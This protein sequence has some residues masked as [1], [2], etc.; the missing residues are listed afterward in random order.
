MEIMELKEGRY[1]RA[2]QHSAQGWLHRL[3]Q[4]VDAYRP[5]TFWSWNAKLEEPVLRRQITEMK[6]AGM[7]GFFMHARSGLKTPY[8]GDEWFR[9]VEVAMDE[10]QKQNMQAWCYDESGWP[11]GFAGM[12]LL[13]KKENLAHY[14]TFRENDFFDS[15]ALAVYSLASGKLKRLTG[16]TEGVSVYY[17]VYDHTNSSVVDIMNEDI[18]RQ[19]IQLTHEKYYERYGQQFGKKLI[20]FFTDEPQYFRYDTPYSPVLLK[21]YEDLYQE[22]LLD[23]LAMLFLECEDCYKFRYRYWKLMNNQFTKSF[24]KQVYE[25]CDTHNCK[26]TGHAIEE[27]TLFTQMWCCAGV[28]PFYEYEH[29]PGCDWLGRKIGT[30]MTPKQVGSVAQQLGKKQVLTESF[31]CTGWDVTPRELKQILD[32]QYVNGVNTL[33]TH[34]TP[35]SLEGSRKFDHPAFFSKANPWFEQFR[36]FSDYAAKLGCMLAES[37]EYAPVG[38]IHPIHSA[39]LTYNRRDDYHSVQELETDFQELIERLGAAN[40]P[41]HYIDETLLARHGEICGNILKIGNCE[42]ES[43]V[44]PKMRQMDLT[45][46]GFLKKY[47]ENDGRLWLAGEAP[48]YIDGEPANL[49]CFLKSNMTYE[50]LKSDRYFIETKSESIR[51]TYRISDRGDFIYIVN[52]DMKCVAEMVVHVKADGLKRLYLETDEEERLNYSSEGE[53][54]K[55]SLQLI[56]GESAILLLAEEPAGFPPKKSLRPI[57]F[58]EPVMTYSDPN[59]LVVDNVQISDDNLVYTERMPVPA[60][61]DY[62]LSRCEN[63]QVYLK[64]SFSVQEL[65]GTLVLEMEKMNALEIVLNGKLITLEEPGILDEHFISGNILPYIIQ[66]EN[67]LV[68]KIDY[69]QQEHVYDVLYRTPDVT[70][71]LIN[72]LTYDTEIGSIYL[73]GQF[74]VLSN[75][76]LKREKEGIWLL[77]SDVSIGKTCRADMSNITGSGYPF[78]AGKMAFEMEAEVEEPGEAALLLEGRFGGARLLWNDYE[79]EIVLTEN[80]II[81]AS[82]V[83]RKNKVKIILFSG[84]RNF[85]GPHHWAHDFEPKSVMPMMFTMNGNWKNEKSTDYRE[86]YSFTDFGI[87]IRTVE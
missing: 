14:I 69:Y 24:I 61:G 49:S 86:S 20:G 51:S 35:Y 75:Q 15:A 45:T 17:T 63:C 3:Q 47:V 66:G 8:L 5:I 59:I 13:E 16:T 6:E 36:T 19:F 32:W 81:P 27:S 40:I 30:E 85:L 46:V 21:L 84:N 78:F 56:P 83:K 77:D 29:I 9:A 60:A 22:D 37:R 82:Y 53:N 39:Y 38:V 10:A 42:Y 57:L 52:L 72:C 44:I 68:I 48:C 33:C 70:E 80:V 87:K 74:G 31:A 50:E 73:R 4:N 11:S 79:T 65:P 25:W 28:M 7:G 64:Y 62:M 67:Q 18:V 26:L 71:S 58:S 41:H 43:I 54:L 1:E 2:K 34:L 23:G 55:V 12:K 76:P